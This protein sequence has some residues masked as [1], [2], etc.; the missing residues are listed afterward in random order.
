MNTLRAVILGIETLVDEHGLQ[1]KAYNRVF[2]EAGLPWRWDET[3]YAR[4]VRLSPDGDVLDTF[5]RLDRPFWRNSD[6]M[7]HLLAAVKR[8]H[9]SLCGSADAEM[10][11]IDQDMAAVVRVARSL[12]LCLRVITPQGGGCPKFIDGV[13]TAESHRCALSDL[14]VPASAC[15][16]IECTA[17]GFAAAAGAGI[18]I[19]DKLAFSSNV[20][21]ADDAAVMSLLT[22]AHASPSVVQADRNFATALFA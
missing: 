6:D 20:D 15:I 12:A 1:R 3:D 10:C 8:R 9:A 19:L 16:S 21:V 22:G 18:P 14:S 7:K 13:P 2:E 5:I 17:A 4:L 11:D